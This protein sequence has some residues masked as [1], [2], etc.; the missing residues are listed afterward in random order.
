VN[1]VKKIFFWGGAVTLKIYGPHVL[2]WGP[3]GLS[4]H[5]DGP[6][7]W[8]EANIPYPPFFRRRSRYG[9]YVMATITEWRNARFPYNLRL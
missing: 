1:T 3:I 5:R 2:R 8:C 6:L 7:Q 4:R 9:R